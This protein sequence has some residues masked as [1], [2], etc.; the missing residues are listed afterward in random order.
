M[1]LKN[2]RHPAG[3]NPA[4]LRFCLVTVNVAFDAQPV[5]PG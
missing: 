5:E 2:R 1:D 4:I 3:V